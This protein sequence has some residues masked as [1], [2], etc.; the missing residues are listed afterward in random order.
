MK[1]LW[2]WRCKMEMPMLDDEEFEQVVS[3]SSAGDPFSGMLAEY[4]RI[5]GYGETNPNAIY[6]HRLSLYG[7][8]C[9]SCE[10]PLRTPQAKL[11]GA[12]MTPFPREGTYAELIAFRQVTARK[13]AILVVDDEAAIREIICAML[14]A[15][16]YRCQT[17]PGG[18]EALALLESGEKIHLILHDLLNAPMDGVTLLEHLTKDYPSL[19]VVVA[20]AIH[21]T[22]I[23]RACFQHGAFNYLL[24]PFERTE[25]LTVARDA[26]VYGR[27][28]LRNPERA[29]RMAADVQS[30]Q[31]AKIIEA[32]KVLQ[33]N[34]VS[35]GAVPA[36]TE[37]YTQEQSWPESPSA[38]DDPASSV[39]H[40]TYAYRERKVWPTVSTVYLKGAWITGVL[41][42]IGCWMYA[43]ATYGFLFGVGLGWLPS[44]IVAVIAAYLWPLLLLGGII[45]AMLIFSH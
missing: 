26:L 39:S 4:E 10:K 32:E 35:A 11:C 17:V 43:I 44:A 19:P 1:M 29:A 2:C 42:F 31:L 24:H 9:H 23:A 18:T 45:L 8:P 40:P 20:T 38:S 7:P 25:L 12:C 30:R 41:T 36:A 5:T 21:D 33:A 27:L 34:K 37:D 28:K 13:A 3:R 22:S 15:A 6:H 16:G 14:T